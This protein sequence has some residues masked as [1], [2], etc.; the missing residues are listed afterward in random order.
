V[1][2]GGLGAL[3]ASWVQAVMQAKLVAWK[4]LAGKV[5]RLGPF[6]ALCFAEE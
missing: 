4:Y 6:P 2:G 1:Q 3:S 5:L